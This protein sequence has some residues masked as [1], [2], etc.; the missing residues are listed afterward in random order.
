MD[1]DPILLLNDFQDK[2]KKFLNS[3]AYYPP[4]IDIKIFSVRKCK[5]I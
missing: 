4:K 1:P 3:F 5:K 2:E